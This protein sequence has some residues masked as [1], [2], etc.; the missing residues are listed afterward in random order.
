[1]TRRQEGYTQEYLVEQVM[2][3]SAEQSWKQSMSQLIIAAFN[4]RIVQHIHEKLELIDKF[5]DAIFMECL[6]AK[7]KEV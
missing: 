3:S 1:M 6:N 5:G 2:K 7:A 4:I